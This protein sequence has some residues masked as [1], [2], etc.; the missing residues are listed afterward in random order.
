MCDH[1][2]SHQGAHLPSMVEHTEG[3]APHTQRELL[4]MKG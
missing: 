4:L 2:A 3:Q 1:H